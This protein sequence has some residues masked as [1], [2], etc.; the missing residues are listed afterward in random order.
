[1]LVRRGRVI[2]R[3]VHAVAVD[4]RDDEDLQAVDERRRLGVGAVVAHEALR[5]LE[6][7]ARGRDLARVL[8]A[9]EVHADLGAVARLADA[10]HRTA[11]AGRAGPSPGRAAGRSA[12]TR[13]SAGRRRRR[14]R[15]CGTWSRGRGWTTCGL[16]LIAAMT[17]FAVLVT[18]PVALVA[19]LTRIALPVSVTLERLVVRPSGGTIW[20]VSVLPPRWP[21][22]L[23]GHHDRARAAG[24]VD[25]AEPA[26]G[27]LLASKRTYGVVA[28]GASASC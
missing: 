5:G 24:A 4:L 8:L 7:D 6:A 2:D 19:G 10:Q 12:A 14:R 1:M 13:C 9:V 15:G 3:V 11:S 18:A 28:F 25:G 17:S 22:S 20:A 26:T 21:M 27:R 16:A 23:R